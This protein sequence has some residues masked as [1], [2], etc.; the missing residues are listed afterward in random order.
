[1]RKNTTLI[2]AI[3]LI[4]LFTIS[5]NECMDTGVYR[6]ITDL[7][8]YAVLR[9]AHRMQTKQGA[10]VSNE[11]HAVNDTPVAIKIASRCTNRL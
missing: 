7:S 11:E 8:V 1:M 2:R 6:G 9:V 3:C 4:K 10:L 5:I